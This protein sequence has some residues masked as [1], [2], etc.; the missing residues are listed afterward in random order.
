MVLINLARAGDQTSAASGAREAGL[1][2]LKA[3]LALFAVPVMTIGQAAPFSIASGEQTAGPMG[4]LEGDALSLWHNEQFTA[5]LDAS[6]TRIIYLCGSWLEEDIFI[7]AL[8]GAERG[9]EIRLLSDLIEARSND[10]RALAFDRLASHGV[11][12]G[13]VRQMLLEWA[14]FC[15]DARLKQ[16]VLRLLS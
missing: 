10:D 1:S 2:L 5:A 3:G 6:D 14:A 12:A 11:L 7:V 9:Y 4:E 16:S 8:Q 15:D 13:T